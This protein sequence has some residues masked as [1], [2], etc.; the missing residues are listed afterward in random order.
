MINST[1]PKFAKWMRG[2]GKQ[3]VLKDAEIERLERA[4]TAYSGVVTRSD[5]MAKM[6]GKINPMASLA[7][8]FTEDEKKAMMIQEEKE[9][10]GRFKTVQMKLWDEI[11]VVEGL[12]LTLGSYKWRQSLSTVEVFVRLPP[13][14]DVKRHVRIDIQSTSLSIFLGP[15]AS[16]ISGQ[17]LKSVEA[18]TSSWYCMDDVLHISMFKLWR[19]GRYE[20]GKGCEETWWGALFVDSDKIQSLYP[21][22]F[23]YSLPREDEERNSVPLRRLAIGN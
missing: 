3:A 16:E 22:S 1:D 17:L 23:Y 11:E 8:S 14:L 7:P 20:P 15:E 13:G 21:P 12:G 4:S 2:H 6:M 9:S 10:S 5:L 18:K 19:K